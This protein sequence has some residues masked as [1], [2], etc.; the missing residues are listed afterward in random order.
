MQ[1]S[2]NN[3]QLDPYTSTFMRMTIS[4]IRQ[5][6]PRLW[7]VMGVCSCTA[8]CNSLLLCVACRLLF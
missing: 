3:E 2:D 7:C 5:H 4:N 1:T 6:S 8:C